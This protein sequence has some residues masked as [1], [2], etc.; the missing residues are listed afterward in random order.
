MSK[1]TFENYGR[2]ARLDEDSTLVSGRYRIQKSAERLI[3]SDIAQK[4]T[5]EPDDKL[6]EIGC[7]SGNLLIPLSFMVESAVGIDHPDVCEYI[8]RRCNDPKIELIGANFL[9]Y[10]AGPQFLFDK[11]LIYSVLNTL[12]HEE[13]AF[14]FLDKAVALLTPQ[15]RLLIGDIANVDC[16]TRFLSTAAG[17][18]FDGEWKAKLNLSPRQPPAQ[19]CLEDEILLRPSDEFILSLIQRYR[20]R[21]FGTYLL[22]QPSSLPFG[23]TREDVLVVAP[24]L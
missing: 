10:E 8:Q 21:G 16:K 7:G 3:V 9:D 12:S 11:I 2:L 5:I 4:L 19:D 23:R 17:R 15:G 13:E 6:L 14:T 24:E 18:M 20:E 22:P 1:L